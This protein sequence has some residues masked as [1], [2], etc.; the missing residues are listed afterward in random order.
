MSRPGTLIDTQLLEKISELPPLLDLF[1]RN[2]IR[3]KGDKL[4]RTNWNGEEQEVFTLMLQP[5]FIESIMKTRQSLMG[6]TSN[7]AYAD[8]IPAYHQSGELDLLTSLIKNIPEVQPNYAGADVGS[9]SDHGYLR[10]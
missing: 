8:L 7:C 2:G 1:S 6:A 9:F 10:G 4:F 3:I 5:V